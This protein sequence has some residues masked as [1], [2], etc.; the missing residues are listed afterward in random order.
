M[1]NET[2]SKSLLNDV[3]EFGKKYNI[4]LNQPAQ[5]RRKTSIPTRF[6]DS[7]LVTTTT[8]GHRDR[9]NQESFDT[10]EEKFRNKLF[11]LITDLI[12]VKLNDRFS[13]ENIL[14]LSSVLAVHPHRDY[15]L[16]IEQLKPLAN[17]RTLDT[18]K[19]ENELR[20]IQHFIQE[21]RTSMKTIQD[22]L[23]ELT[24]MNEAFPE[25]ISLLRGAL[26]SP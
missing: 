4:N 10:N 9:G 11:H 8:I 24:P 14:L 5:F 23:Y 18:N 26:Y 19:L 2:I 12:L 22:L 6:Q 25:T 15:V 20:V 16:D 7:V 21:K 13:D 3:V 1:R 17:H